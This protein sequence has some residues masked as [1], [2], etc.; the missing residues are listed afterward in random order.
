MANKELS[1]GAKIYL[2]SGKIPHLTEGFCFLQS[3]TG[4]NVN[5]QKLSEGIII[6]SLIQ[7]VKDNKLEVADKSKKVL[8]MV[9]PILSL[10]RK[11]TGGIGLGKIILDQLSEEKDLTKVIV[12]IL[13]GRYMLPENVIAWKVEKELRDL[14]LFTEKEVKKMLGVT[15][16]EKVWDEKKVKDLNSKYQAEAEKAF[17]ETLDV[18][19]RL[20][21]IRNLHIAWGQTRTPK[22]DDHDHNH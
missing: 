20:T 17:Q 4:E 7:L 9:A 5:Y 2:A 14:S 1:I 10:K 21:A 22:K 11:A 16:T 18:S 3:P 6:A 19:W 12:D 15:R 13:G 8:F